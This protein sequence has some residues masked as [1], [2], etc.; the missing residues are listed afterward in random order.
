[1][2]NKTTTELLDLLWKI[3]SQKEPDWEKYDQVCAEL[4][5]RPPFKN[6]G[7]NNNDESHDER[8]EELEGDVKLLRRHKHDPHSGDVM[9][10][11]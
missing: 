1:M 3:E 7:I 5:K 11:I 10:R 4:E 2:E 9:V 6:I 8:I